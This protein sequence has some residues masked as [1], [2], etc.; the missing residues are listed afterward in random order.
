MQFSTGDSVYRTANLD[1]QHAAEQSV[2]VDPERRRWHR[3]DDGRRVPGAPCMLS[4][5]PSPLWP[6]GIRTAQATRAEVAAA[7]RVGGAI[8]RFAARATALSS[9]RLP[10]PVSAEFIV[11]PS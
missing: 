4:H 9:G 11:V 1:Q 2:H 10:A 6:V 8:T 3:G 7:C 5:L